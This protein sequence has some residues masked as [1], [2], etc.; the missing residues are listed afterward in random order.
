MGLFT[1][2][3]K[4]EAE[5]RE[6]EMAEYAQKKAQEDRV[7]GEFGRLYVKAGE[8][9]S[10]DR[11][12]LCGKAMFTN[13]TFK[14]YVKAGTQ[15]VEMLLSLEQDAILATCADFHPSLLILTSEIPDLLALAGSIAQK[16]PDTIIIA[17]SK[18]INALPYTRAE[19]EQ[20]HVFSVLPV[21]CS[22]EKFIDGM[23]AMRLQLQ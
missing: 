1:S 18:D 9:V 17:S 19:L 8:L 21:P 12:L 15:D 6:R 11:L 3:K 23:S 4:K 14:D 5:A 20:V 13:M 22:I 10:H 7:L 2:K 16:Y